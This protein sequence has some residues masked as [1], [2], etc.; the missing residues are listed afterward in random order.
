M[1]LEYYRLRILRMNE[2]GSFEQEDLCLKVNGT[3]SQ[4]L[5]NE[6]QLRGFL[7]AKLEPMP[8]DALRRVIDR[9]NPNQVS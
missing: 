8:A 1:T 3:N 6:P 7:N 9:V 5:I 4:V 2:Q